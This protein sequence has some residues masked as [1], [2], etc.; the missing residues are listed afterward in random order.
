VIVNKLWVYLISLCT[1]RG[2]RVE[3]ACHHLIFSGS[4]KI[5]ICPGRQCPDMETTPSGTGGHYLSYSEL[6]FVGYG[7]IK[8]DRGEVEAS[9]DT[10]KKMQQKSAQSAEQEKK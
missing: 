9:D 2:E 6:M 3:Q 10:I 5:G 8:A 1:L 7:Q 4:N